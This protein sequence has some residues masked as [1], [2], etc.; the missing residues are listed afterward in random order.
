L[1]A[2][3]YLLKANEQFADSPRSDHIDSFITLFFNLLLQ[4]CSVFCRRSTMKNFAAFLSFAASS[5]AA[6]V[7]YDWDITWV[8][9]APD[10]FSRPVIGI[11][12]AWPLPTIEATVGDTV[13]VTITNQLGN[14]TTSLHFHGISQKGSNT[15]D[16]PSG[17]NQCPVPPGSSFT[18]TFTVSNYLWK[19]KN[20]LVVWKYRRKKHEQPQIKPRLKRKEKRRKISKLEI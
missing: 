16:G 8:N 14:E 1:D 18:Y 6:T 15:M 9:A 11:N 5:L 17:V 4:L 7:T 12:N 19:K 3:Q 13:V 20:L 2:I 10:G